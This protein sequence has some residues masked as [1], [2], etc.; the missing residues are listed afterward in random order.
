MR[1]K[2]IATKLLKRVCA[3]AKADGCDFIEGYPH[4][5]ECDMYAAHHGTTALFEKYGFV[6]HK[7]FGK[8]C[9]M[10]KYLG[11]G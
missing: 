5:G 3:D 9:I 7:Q 6:I 1:G 4:T 11:N 8:E 2:G 10:R